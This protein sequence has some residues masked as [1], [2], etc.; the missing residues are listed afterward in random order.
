MRHLY[1]RLLERLLLDGVEQLNERTGKRV[2]VL[3]GG[4]SFSL[5]LKDGL[6]PVAGG[7]R[8][9]PATAA[10]ELAWFLSGSRDVRWL[11]ERGCKI[12]SKFRDNAATDDISTAYGYRW[13]KYFGRDQIKLAIE[14]LAQEP[15]SRQVLVSAWSAMNDGLGEKAPNFPCPTHFTLWTLD[16]ELHMSVFMRSSDVFVGL[17]YDVMG[18]ALLLDALAASLCRQGCQVW[19]GMMTF[20]LSHAHLYEPHWDM[21]HSVAERGVDGDEGVVPM[22]GWPVDAIQSDPDVYIGLVKA[23]EDEAAWPKYDPR[24]EL[25]L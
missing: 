4:T 9:R 2:K 3:R 21:A 12:W 10:K 5:D 25:V 22:P 14:T 1:R 11:E 15:S 7:R 8:L 18:H 24:P 16:R 17:P 19:P 20:H 6:L 23:A 13:R